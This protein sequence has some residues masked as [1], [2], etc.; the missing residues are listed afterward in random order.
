MMTYTKKQISEISGLSLR[1]VQFYTE[2]G[3][4][5]PEKNS[6]QGRGNVRI[7]SKRSLLDFLVIAELGHYGITKK[8]IA[9]FLEVFRNKPIFKHYFEDPKF[10]SDR[11]FGLFFKDLNSNEV[12]I[13][14][15]SLSENEK[16]LLYFNE[17]EKMLS[18][19]NIKDFSSLIV[20]NLGELFKK[21]ENI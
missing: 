15:I 6:G 12:F 13:S 19:N 5:L 3:L 7:F 1:L 8:K 14:H 4:V 2:E 20:I 21:A 11:L 17:I 9:E 10:K 18:P 16:T